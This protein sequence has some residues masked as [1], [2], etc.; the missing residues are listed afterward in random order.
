[1]RK[2]EHGLLSDRI[3]HLILL[4][5]LLENSKFDLDLEC[6]CFVVCVCVCVCGGGGGGV[7]C[8]DC[9]AHNFGPIICIIK[10]K[11]IQISDTV[12]N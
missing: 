8:V 5:L 4:S 11:M 7:D 3:V 9:S 6:V 12:G 1:M 2:K 10:P